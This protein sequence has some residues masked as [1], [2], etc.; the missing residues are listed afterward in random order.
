MSRSYSRLSEI[1]QQQ[2]Q[3]QQ[4]PPRRRRLALNSAPTTPSKKQVIYPVYLRPEQNI[5]EVFANAMSTG[6]KPIGSSS[7][8][9]NGGIGAKQGNTPSDDSKKG[10]CGSIISRDDIVVTVRSAHV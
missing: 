4:Q 9:C 7:S 10:S 6:F 3:Q 1:S 5:P 8:N 2:Q